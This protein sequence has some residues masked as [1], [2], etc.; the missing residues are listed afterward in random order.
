MTARVQSGKGGGHEAGRGAGSRPIMIHVRREQ[1]SEL[2]LERNVLAVTEAT[3]ASLEPQ[4]PAVAEDECALRAS[5]MGHCRPFRTLVRN[6][7]E[8]VLRPGW[9]CVLVT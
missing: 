2:E 5:E 1:A 8:A 3:R 4:R 9:R 6:S 7:L